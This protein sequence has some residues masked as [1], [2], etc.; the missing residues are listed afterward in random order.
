MV[1]DCVAFDL[2]SLTEKNEENE[3]V[4]VALGGA[5]GG[6]AI[7]VGAKGQAFVW[8]VVTGVTL[9]KWV[10]GAGGGWDIFSSL[11]AHTE[12]TASVALTLAASDSILACVAT[13]ISSE[14]GT[15]DSTF[16]EV[17][18]FLLGSHSA[19]VVI[20]TDNGFQGKRR[21]TR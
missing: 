5:A 21:R 2:S 3:F 16:F 10:V 1:G 6:Y 20:N 19:G 7:V 11:S 17:H 4:P 8:D 12:N 9:G 13:A 18:R 14:D 15:K